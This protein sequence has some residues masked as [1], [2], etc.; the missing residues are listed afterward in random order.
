MADSGVATGIIPLGKDANK[1]ADMLGVPTGV[2]ACDV[3]SARIIEEV[4]IGVVNGL[5]FL[6]N[7]TIDQGSAC[8]VLCDNNYT[9]LFDQKR[10]A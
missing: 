7:L 5:R 6:H 10:S 8:Q 1:I 2:A 3:I 9:P 4:D